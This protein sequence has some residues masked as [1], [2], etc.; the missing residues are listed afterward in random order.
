MRTSPKGES[1]RRL[2]KSGMVPRARYDALVAR[3]ED[4]EDQLEMIKIDREAASRDGK[5]SAD[6]LPDELVGRLLGGAHPVD[7]WRTHRSYTL[8]RLEVLSGVPASYISE[9]VNGKKPGSADALS[10]LAKA[11]DIPLEDLTAWDGGNALPEIA[12]LRPVLQEPTYNPITDRVWFLAGVKKDAVMIVVPRAV[13]EGLAG[14]NKLDEVDAREVVKKN[15][16][17]LCKIASRKYAAHDFDDGNILIHP[18][19]LG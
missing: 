11:L 1:D 9:I 6:A 5:P 10:R 15:R 3:I 4:L 12:P 14:K 13:F 18:D 16:G 7:V 8:V 17:Y 2:R 19:D